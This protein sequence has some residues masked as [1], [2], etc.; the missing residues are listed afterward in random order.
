MAFV[1]LSFCHYAISF[2]VDFGSNCMKSWQG[3]TYRPKVNSPLIQF[4]FVNSSNKIV[5]YGKK[6]CRI[7][8]RVTP[9][10]KA[11]FQAVTEPDS[12]A[13]AINPFT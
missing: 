13:G 12:W 8:S 10:S 9:K 5:K 1:L 2:N 7:E 6:F 3:K 4:Y 11:M